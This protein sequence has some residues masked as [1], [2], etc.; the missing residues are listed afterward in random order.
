MVNRNTNN[1]FSQLTNVRCHDRKKAGN[2]YTINLCTFRRILKLQKFAN[3]EYFDFSEMYLHI[4]QPILFMTTIYYS[5]HV[6]T[7]I[8]FECECLIL[9]HINPENVAFINNMKPQHPHLPYFQHL[10]EKADK[11]SYNR[12]CLKYQLNHYCP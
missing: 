1:N 3:Y 6:V 10:Y 11:I 12:V 7:I 2:I 8:I 9:L 5:T 4:F